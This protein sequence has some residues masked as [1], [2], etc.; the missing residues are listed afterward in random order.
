MGITL[1][2][3]DRERL[4]YGSGSRGKF[5]PPENG[6]RAIF[7]PSFGV[8]EK[9]E[10]DYLVEAE[11]EKE[12]ERLRSGK[13]SLQKALL[14]EVVTE[15]KKAKPGERGKRAKEIMEG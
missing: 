6:R 15:V 9:E 5:I 2:F 13:I 10:V 14:E 7:V 1:I 11:K 8:L 12:D 3:K 4:P